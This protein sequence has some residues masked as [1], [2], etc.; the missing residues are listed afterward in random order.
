ML[1]DWC[2]TYTTIYLVISSSGTVYHFIQ[3]QFHN[4][5]FISKCPSYATHTTQQ[6]WVH[7][8]FRLPGSRL[9]SRLTSLHWKLMTY[10]TGSSPN[11][12]LCAAHLFLTHNTKRGWHFIYL[13]MDHKSFEATCQIQALIVCNSICSQR[14][15]DSVKFRIVTRKKLSWL[16][17]LWWF[18]LTFD[19]MKLL[20]ASKLWKSW[21]HFI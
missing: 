5:G 15:L 1:C 3:G 7:L 8:P 4:L 9:A 21:F 13:F 14:R 16:I 10:C 20:F 17:D 6:G 12:K 19:L 11:E 18:I 2:Y